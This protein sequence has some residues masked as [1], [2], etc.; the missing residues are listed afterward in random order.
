MQIP[1]E[2]SY[3]DINK[4]YELEKLI[5][6]KTNKLEKVCD[7]ITSCHIAIEKP[8]KYPDFGSPYRIRIDIRIPPGHEVVI[9][10][11]PGD[12]NMNEPLYSIVREAFDAAR[13]KTKEV[14]KIQNSK[15]KTH[16]AQETVAI[17]SE[18]YSEDGYGFIKTVNG[19]EIYFHKNS[20]LHNDFEKLKSGTSVRFFE[21]QGA[22][23]PQASTVQIVDKPAA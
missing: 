1:L 22:K 21:E 18:L 11:E 6:E 16:P 8:Q 10:R 5:R 2:I 12:D 3:R 20:V 17:V 13:R 23:G 9:K 4:T 19:R 7:H 14:C 15:I